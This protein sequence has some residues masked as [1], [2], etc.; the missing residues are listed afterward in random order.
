M[1]IKKNLIYNDYYQK[2]YNTK[3]LYNYLLILLLVYER[4]YMLHTY[5]QNSTA[6]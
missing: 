3:Q 2:Y 6:L 1:K 5:I 4:C